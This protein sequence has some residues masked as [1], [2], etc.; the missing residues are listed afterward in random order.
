MVLHVRPSHAVHA[1][2]LE[3]LSSGAWTT[4]D[5]RTCYT[6]NPIHDTPRLKPFVGRCV[7][8]TAR[9]PNCMMSTKLHDVRL[10]RCTIFPHSI[11]LVTLPSAKPSAL[12]CPSQTR[13]HAATDR[14][15]ACRPRDP[16][17]AP[18]GLALAMPMPQSSRQLELQPTPNASVQMKLHAPRQPD[19]NLKDSV[20]DV[21]CSS[22]LTS[23]WLRYVGCEVR[24]ACAETC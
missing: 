11:L 16:R 13:G 10:I 18:P 17:R 23:H 12:D 8:E 14:R 5:D 3:A 7:T 1:L 24:M 20:L 22:G 6:N 19:Q 21:A 15:P 4:C 9:G 2:G